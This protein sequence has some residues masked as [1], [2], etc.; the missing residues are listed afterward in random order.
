MFINV[1]IY[2]KN[3][4]CGD[5]TKVTLMQ[6]VCLWWLWDT[7]W[8]TRMRAFFPIKEGKLIDNVKEKLD[9]RL[10]FVISNNLKL[11]NIFDHKK[12]YW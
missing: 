11:K 3:A 2:L 10:L 5:V 4:P 9:S 1:Y 7:V 8:Q 12:R 6:I